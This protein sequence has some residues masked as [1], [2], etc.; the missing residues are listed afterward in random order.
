[1]SPTA[2][3]VDYFPILREFLTGETSDAAL[4]ALHEVVELN[5]HRDQLPQGAAE[6]EAHLVVSLMPGSR[7]PANL[8]GQVVLPECE[9]WC[10]GARLRDQTQRENSV[11]LEMLLTDA[12]ADVKDQ[13]MTDGVLMTATKNAPAS[14]EFDPDTD[15]AFQRSV[16]RTSFSIPKPA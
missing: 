15:R 5:V 2:T 12:L 11:V 4:L 9:M 1:M 3:A 6:D 7:Q 16:W 8:R 10:Y 13:E 14:G